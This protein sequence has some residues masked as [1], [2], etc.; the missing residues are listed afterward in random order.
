MVY[1]EDTGTTLDIA[2]DELAAFLDSD[3]HSTVHSDDVRN[4]EVVENIPPAMVVSF[5][6]KFEGGWRKS[7]TRITSFPPYCRF[8]EELEGPFAGSRFVGTH[9]P[10]GTKTR[11]DVFG[12]VECEGM[13][14]EQ[15][16]AFWLGVLAKSHDEDLAALRN[17]RERR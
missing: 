7:S 17:F 12:D 15:L 8:I 2:F 6:R 1:F 10:D 11:V 3:E 14:P 16:R 4:F 13:T 5:E 9:R